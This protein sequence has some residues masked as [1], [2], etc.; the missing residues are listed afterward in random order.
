MIAY[1]EKH[2]FDQVGYDFF[3]VSLP[4]IEVFAD[5]I[6]LRNRQYCN[7]LRA[8]GCTGLGRRKEARQLTAEI[9]NRQP[10]YQGAL[11]IGNI[12]MVSE[13]SLQGTG[14]KQPT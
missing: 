5:D 7:Y 6:A 2:L 3:A 13:R 11:E 10:D 14:A 12:S 9:L 8:L 4:E 1:G